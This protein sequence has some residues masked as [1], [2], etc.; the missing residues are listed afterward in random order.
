MRAEWAKLWRRVQIATGMEDDVAP[1]TDPVVVM[2][3]PNTPILMHQFPWEVTI[4]WKG[5]EGD[6]EFDI[7]PMIDSGY[8]FVMP[9]LDYDDPLISGIVHI[10]Y[11]AGGEKDQ[12]EA[13]WHT[14]YDLE[15]NELIQSITITAM[16]P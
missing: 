14:L 5:Q 9:S 12:P 7:S 10:P 13:E 6:E 4:V 3:Y 11:P 1:E 16:R 2:N 8:L 15:R